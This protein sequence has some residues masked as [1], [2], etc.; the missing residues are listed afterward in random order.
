MLWS[1]MFYWSAERVSD[2]PVP[3]EG[4]WIFLQYRRS[5]GL[6][7]VRVGWLCRFLKIP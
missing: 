5:L 7:R 4:K 1:G 3:P 2:L 6:P